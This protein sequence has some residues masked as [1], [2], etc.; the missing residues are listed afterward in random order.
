MKNH[1]FIIPKVAMKSNRE[2]TKKMKNRRNAA[3]RSFKIVIFVPG[4]RIRQGR[5]A[6]VEDKQKKT[7]IHFH[8]PTEVSRVARTS[9]ITRAACMKEIK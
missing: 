5:I 3:N 1:N 8:R 2:R 9:K 7:S 6:R 4:K